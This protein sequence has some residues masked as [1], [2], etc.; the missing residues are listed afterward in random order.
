MREP[1]PAAPAETICT[2][3]AW[4]ES[5]W[6]SEFAVVS[7][8]LVAMSTEATVLAISAFFCAPVT[9]TTTSP[10]EKAACAERDVGG[11]R[12]AGGHANRGLLCFVADAVDLELDGARRDATNGVAT[13]FARLGA[14]LRGADADARA[15]DRRCR[16]SRR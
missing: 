1:P 10:S 16:W 6:P 5:S 8:A 7:V 3:A 4:P 14:E 13:V 2:P 9:V 12:L 15:A 11:R